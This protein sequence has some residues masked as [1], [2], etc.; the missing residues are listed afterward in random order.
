MKRN[1]LIT[2]AAL[3]SLTVSVVIVALTGCE[4]EPSTGSL[5]KYF[6]N[7][8][9]ISDPRSAPANAVVQISP[10]SAAV[11]AV[12]EQV[13]FSVKGGAGPYSWGVANAN[14]TVTPQSASSHAIYT[15]TTI[16]ANHV[17][18]ND[19]T[20]HAA[21]GDISSGVGTV[22]IS[23]ASATL[24]PGTL[25]QVLSASGGTPPYVWSPHSGPGIVA[26]ATGSQTVFT[27]GAGDTHTTAVIRVTD[28]T[29]D[30]AFSTLTLD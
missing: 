14:G 26:P 17:I 13:H 24:D 19:S 8:P 11:T 27:R 10:E 9:Y 21:I 15:V 18:V 28:D 5:D 6:A 20:G 23:P 1:T 25:T 2:P 22:A 29:G 7:N 12:G 16:A 4:D 3:L 30:Q